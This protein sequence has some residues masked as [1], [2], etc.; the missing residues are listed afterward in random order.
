MC[1]VV[2]LL[3]VGACQCGDTHS[4]LPEH[5]TQ[6]EQQAEEQKQTQTQGGEQTGHSENPEPQTDRHR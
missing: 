6:E 4:E 3:L 2:L 1:F 5:S